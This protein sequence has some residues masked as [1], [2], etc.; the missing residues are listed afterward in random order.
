MEH[1]HLRH[2]PRRI[3]G[4]LRAP[5]PLPRQRAPLRLGAAQGEFL[6][7]RGTELPREEVRAA[8]GDLRPPGPLARRALPPHRPGGVPQPAH[9][10][11]ARAA[12]GPAGPVRLRAAPDQRLPLPGQGGDGPAGT[13]QLRPG[14]Q[15]VEGLPVPGRPGGRRYR[16][17]ARRQDG[18]C[19]PGG[20]GATGG[21]AG[22]LGDRVHHGPPPPPPAQRAGAA[23]RP[24]RSGAGRPVLPDPQRQRLG[25]SPARRAGGHH[26]AGFPAHGPL[27]ALCGSPQ[28]HRPGVPR[29]D[30]P[31]GFGHRGGGQRGDPGPSRHPQRRAGPCGRTWTRW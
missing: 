28:R 2:R 20:A 15:E 8:A 23:P 6:R 13:R 3:G 9:L 1:P 19:A 12:A 22:Q 14:E 11:Q 17:R 4:Q 7:A 31:R 10:L 16:P 24:H 25:P 21:R 29:E 18:P 26:G 27:V 30:E 5:R